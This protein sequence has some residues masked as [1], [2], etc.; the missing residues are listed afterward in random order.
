MPSEKTLLGNLPPDPRGFVG[1]QDEL[2]WL[3]E[4]LEPGGG[5]RLVTLVGVGG[6]GKTRLALRAAERVGAVY[7]DGVWLVE[8]SPVRAAGQVPLAVMEA[9]R[10]SDQ[11]AGSVAGA[12]GDWMADKRLLLILDTCEHLL[13]DCAVLVADLLAGAAGLHVLV[14]SREPLDLP[15]ERTL[16]VDPLRVTDAETLFVQRAGLVLDTTARR[17]VADI[18]RS[19]DGIPLAIELAV[20]RLALYSL[21]KLHELLS[22][23]L[24][25]RFDVLTRDERSVDGP[26]RHWTLRTTIGWSHEL[27]APLERLLWARLSVFADTFTVAAAT[28]VCAGGPLRADRVAE[29]LM[30]LVRQSIVLRHPTD[31]D[32]FRL[33]DTVREYGADWLRELGEGDAVRLR[34]RDHYRRFAREACADWNTSRQVAWCERVLAEHANLRAAMDRALEEPAGR[35]ALEMAGTIGFLWRH[36][37]MM[38]DAARCLD[39]VLAAEHEPGADLVRALWSRSA[40][41]INQGDLDPACRWATRCADAARE[42]GDPTTIAATAYVTGSTAVLTGR[43]AEAIDLLS[44]APRLPLGADWQGSAQLQIRMALCFAHLL[45]GAIDEAREV[46]EQARADSVRCGEQWGRP[47]IDGLIAQTDLARGDVEAAQANARAGVVGSR[48]TH[49]T[50]GTALTFDWLVAAVVAGGDSRRAAG[51]EGIS[52]RLW[53]RVGRAQVNSPHLIAAREARERLLR[54]RLGDQLYEEAYAQ[55]MAMPYDEGL[56]YALS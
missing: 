10:L 13:A 9:V 7:P 31:L 46:A 49:N 8:L 50:V 11:S 26:P 37:G 43:T 41:A 51:L 14:T 12:L 27:C 35:A 25:S 54:D 39:L 30:H 56:D 55:G 33:L 40:V 4:K 42:Q 48:L 19:L 17:Q 6:V 44:A 1:R 23:R 47:V 45:T 53:E 16:E 28:W 24:R 36:C 15:G 18:C 52:R 20:A 29:V 3:A 2:G 38:R 21:D 22:D 5:T 32:R 34:H